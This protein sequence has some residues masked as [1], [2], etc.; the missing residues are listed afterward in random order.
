[1]RRPAA[2]LE[3]LCRRPLM[4][5]GRADA[6][7]IERVPQMPTG[8]GPEV[9]FARR[10]TT[11]GAPDTWARGIE[12]FLLIRFTINDNGWLVVR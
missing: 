3:A 8:A 2:T 5:A 7:R 9:V 6:S 11:F 4:K 12:T 1:M 10:P